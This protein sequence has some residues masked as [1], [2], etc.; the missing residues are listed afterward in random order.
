VSWQ[1]PPNNDP[2][3]PPPPPSSVS[4]NPMYSPEVLAAKAA[5]VAADARNALIMSIIGIFCFGFILGIIAY[6]KANEALETIAIYD[7]A[8]EKKGIATAAKILG[9]IDIVFWALGLI[10]RFAL[11]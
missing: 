1:Q 11:R 8:K 6:R 9:I 3:V 4:G 7:V 2:F 10:A 5:S